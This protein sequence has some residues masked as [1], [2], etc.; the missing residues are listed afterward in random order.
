MAFKSSLKIDE[1]LQKICTKYPQV[2]MAFLKKEWD[3]LTQE[4]IVNEE[5]KIKPVVKEEKEEVKI[6]P[7][8]KEENEEMKIKPVVKEEKE[9][10]KIKPVVKEENEEMKIKPVVKEEN[11]EMKIKPVVKEEKEEVKIKPV[12][13]E[14]KEE[15][16]IVVKEVK[17]KTVVKEEKEEVKIVV[18]EE[19]EE[20]KIKP[21]VE[22]NTSHK[23]LQRCCYKFVRAPKIG[24]ICGV[25]IKTI[26]N[27]YCSKHKKFEQSETKVVEKLPKVEA[28]KTLCVRLDPTTGKFVHKESKLVFYSNKQL[29]VCGKLT[30]GGILSL[31]EKDLELCKKYGFK[32]YNSI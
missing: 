15:V 2:D 25:Q 1:F 7:V 16:K 8:V 11:E 26:G 10:V 28:N 23:V 32:I 6:K 14:E 30:D 5:M 27:S 31:D 20:M 3:E 21:N 9:E 24:E 29:E 4:P 18:K 12:V 19:K 17:I 13:K 22:S